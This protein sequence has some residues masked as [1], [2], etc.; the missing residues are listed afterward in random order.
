MVL[1]LSTVGFD[2]GRARSGNRT[3]WEPYIVL[4]TRI[5]QYCHTNRSADG[6]SGQRDADLMDASV[7]AAADQSRDSYGFEVLFF[8]LLSALPELALSCSVHSVSTL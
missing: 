1:L 7:L 8:T 5:E 3:G 2:A 6:G 4:D